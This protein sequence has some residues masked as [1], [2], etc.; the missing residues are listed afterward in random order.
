MTIDTITL[1]EKV[2]ACARKERMR[3]DYVNLILSDESRLQWF[4]WNLY[5]IN[6]QRETVNGKKL[7]IERVEFAVSIKCF[8]IDEADY[9][10]LR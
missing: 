5:S 1:V 6:V 8:I 9:Y 2:Y 4:A 10:C 3:S 7:K